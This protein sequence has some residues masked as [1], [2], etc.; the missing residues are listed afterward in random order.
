MLQERQL[1]PVLD[2]QALHLASESALL[3]RESPRRDTPP[4]QRCYYEC[5]Q[6]WELLLREC[7]AQVA[8]LERLPWEQ[9][10]SLLELRQWEEL[11]LAEVSLVEAPFALLRVL[12]EECVERPLP[13][14]LCPW[15]SEGQR[16]FLLPSQEQL[17]LH[18]GQ[19]CR[20]AE[21]PGLLLPELLE[22]EEVQRRPLP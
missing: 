12:E 13:R 19:A 16:E 11:E 7:P 20:H 5:L 3:R 14:L 6:V 22:R 1:E 2:L 15:C 18:P 10:R 4:V 17:E 9:Q 8:L 21:L